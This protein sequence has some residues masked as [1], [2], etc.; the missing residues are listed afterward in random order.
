MKIRIGNVRTWFTKPKKNVE[1]VAG[2]YRLSLSVVQT[3]ESLVHS[4]N[5][6]TNVSLNKERGAW[7]AHSPGCSFLNIDQRGF[8]VFSPFSVGEN[9]DLK[10]LKHTL[11]FLKSYII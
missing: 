8:E 6:K 9:E 4:Y 7:L 5:K 10:L 1:S 11:Q 2:R 3:R